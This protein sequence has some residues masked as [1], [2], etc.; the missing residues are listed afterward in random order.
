MKIIN[1]SVAL[2]AILGSVPAYADVAI[3]PFSKDL[4]TGCVQG[5]DIGLLTKSSNPI[6]LLGSVVYTGKVLN[7]DGTVGSGLV[8]IPLPLPLVTSDAGSPDI[9]TCEHN[10][11]TSADGNVSFL[12]FS[13]RA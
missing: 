12:G 3:S 7:D 10:F 11:Q 5:R 1:A 4:F 2:L 6:L 9:S 13:L 8:R